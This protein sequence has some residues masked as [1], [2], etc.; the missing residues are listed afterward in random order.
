MLSRDDL[1]QYQIRAIEFIKN[2]KRAFL[3]LDLGLGKT[4]STLTAIADLLD[5]FAVNKVLVIAPLRVANSVWKQ[6]S[7]NWQHLKHLRVQI[8]TGSETKRLSALHND[9]EIYVINRENVTWLVNKLGKKWPFDFVVVDESSSFKNSSS[10]RFKSLRKILPFTNYIALLTGTP[11]P[12]GLQDLWAQCYLVDYGMSLGRTLTNFRNRFFDADYF[13]H[14]YTPKH[15]SDK[16]I[17]NAIRDYSLSMS[18]DDYLELPERVIL[19]E[20]IIL[21]SQ[22]LNQYKDFEKNLFMEFD[23]EEIEAV[24]AAVLAGKLMQFSSGALYTDENKNYKVVHDG[25]IDAIKELIEENQGENILIA[26]NYKSD[27]ERLKKALPQ[28]RVLDKESQTIDDWN[29]GLIPILLAHPASAGH[30]LN[31]QQGGSLIIWFSLNWSL[32]LYQQFN[33]RLH[34]QGQCKPVRI[35]HIIA[36]GTIDER[37]LEVLN[38]KDATQTDLLKALKSDTM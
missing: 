24:N 14:T 16:K 18:S 10:K 8:C 22:V 28:A 32:E 5:G 23:G 20:K 36:D 1:H 34:R 30:G 31:L 29:K 19:R 11:S 27:L 2:R 21:S 35:I 37:V 9:A 17:H 6:E 3:M 33:A 25:K 38:D 7:E 15:G 4:V 26:Y 13:G 12:N